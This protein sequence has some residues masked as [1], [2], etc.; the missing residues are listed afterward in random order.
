MT[1]NA[2]GHIVALGGGGFSVKSEFTALDAFILSLAR[3]ERP[4]VCFIP[5][6]SADS[7]TYIAKFYRAYSGRCVPTDL[8]FNDAPALPRQPP[9][10]SDLADFVSAQDVFF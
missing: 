9:R 4:R 2:T 6:A 10:T 5:T 1:D 7:A 3:R 8:T